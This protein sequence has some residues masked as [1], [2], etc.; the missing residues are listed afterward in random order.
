ME[1]G[2]LYGRGYIRTI[3]ESLPVRDRPQVPG[4]AGSR[5]EPEPVAVPGAGSGHAEPRPVLG[6]PAPAAVGKRGSPH[7]DHT[8]HGVQLVLLSDSAVGFTGHRPLNP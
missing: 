3:G 1:R 7:S 6:L 2:L 4:G 8:S 5:L